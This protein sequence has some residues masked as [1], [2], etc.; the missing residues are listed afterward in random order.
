[1]WPRLLRLLRQY[2]S[3]VVAFVDDDGYPAS[4]RCHPVPDE[5]GEVLVLVP[6]A[7]VTPQEGRGGLLCHS[8]DERL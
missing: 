3:A 6:P 2:P 5:A 8:H 1:V 4:F 7:G